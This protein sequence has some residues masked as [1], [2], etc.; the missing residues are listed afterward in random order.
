MGQLSGSLAH[1]VKLLERFLQDEP[2]PQK[3]L[4][5]ERDLSILLREGGR[6][7]M[8]WVLHRL[9]PE[10][11]AEAPALL[12]LEGRLSRRRRKHRRS[13]ATLFGT[14]VV[15]RRL[16]EPRERGVRAM[17][18]LERRLG[19]E[20]GI[21][22]PALAARVGLWAVDHPQRQVLDMLADDHG[23]QWSCPALRKVLSS[24]RA[25]MEQHRHASQVAQVV[26]W[27]QQARASKG[28]YRPTLAV[29]RDGIF[30]PLRHGVWQEG[31]TATVSVLDRQ[32]ERVGTVYLG[33][34]P[35][36]GQSP[37]TAQLNMMLQDIFRQV[38]SH[39]LR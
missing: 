5:F 8:A 23:V 9:E 18:P 14:V 25:G 21:A 28:R 4:T 36:P 34:M 24:L 35:E 38:N 11:S 7:I 13:V 33:H 27:L 32:G 19:I 2:T 1:G 37:L 39:A 6:R 15:W 3:M 16:Y 26:S 10:V 12:R 20:A 22:T 17:H 31:A 29:G 30:V